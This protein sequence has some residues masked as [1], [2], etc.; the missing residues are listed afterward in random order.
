MDGAEAVFVVWIFL[1]RTS[2]VFTLLT[3]Y[4]TYMTILTKTAATTTNKKYKRNTLRLTK[5][6]NLYIRVTAWS[7]NITLYIVLYLVKEL[8]FIIFQISTF[9]ID[10]Q[11]EKTM[12]AFRIFDQQ[13][14]FEETKTRTVDEILGIR[15]FIHKQVQ[16]QNIANHG[17]PSENVLISQFH[18]MLL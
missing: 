14:Y 13:R 10:R 18:N 16:Q 4:Y 5:S 6:K 2:V 8:A 11:V 1:F 9:Q 17:K 12:Q 3:L 15:K 7:F